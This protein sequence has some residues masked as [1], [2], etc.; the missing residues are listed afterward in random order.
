MDS[1]YK[2]IKY[3]VTV[4]HDGAGDCGDPM[5]YEPSYDT[6]ETRYCV[7]SAETGE[8]ID[9]AQGYGYKTAQKAHAAYAYKHRDKHKV[10]ECAMKRKHIRQWMKHHKEFVEAM[11]YYAVEAAKES[12]DGAGKLDAKFLKKMLNDNNL[13]PDFTPGE[14]LKVWRGR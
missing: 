14:L 13:H 8:I 5:D 3:N 9:D 1:E 11:D 7:V 4:H 12:V 10:T 6:N 2:V